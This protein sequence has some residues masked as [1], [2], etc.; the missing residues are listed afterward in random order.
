MSYQ[1]RCVNCD[2]TRTITQEDCK[3]S[4]HTPKSKAVKIQTRTAE[5]CDNCN[6]VRFGIKEVDN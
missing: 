5:K 6:H 4:I 1:V 3:D 2:E